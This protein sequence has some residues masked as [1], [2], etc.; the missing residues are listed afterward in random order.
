MA[1]WFMKIVQ[2]WVDQQLPMLEKLWSFTSTAT[3][4]VPI[5]LNFFL[6]H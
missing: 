5:S 4:L 6:H 3:I 2:L 1:I